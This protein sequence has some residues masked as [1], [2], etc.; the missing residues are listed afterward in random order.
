MG[1]VWC[2]RSLQSFTDPEYQDPVSGSD[3]FAVL[4]F[5][6][7]LLALALAL[8]MFAQL[9]GSRAV[10]RASL[11]SAAGAATAGV[12]NLLEDALQMGFAFWLFIIGTLLASLGLIVLGLVVA[13][14]CQGRRRL[15][16]AVPVLTLIG[17]MLFE[18]G[19]GVV[20]AAVWLA[21]AAIS[22]RSPAR[23][24]TARAA[25]TTP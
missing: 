7:A 20:I 4:S 10:F 17:F 18:S 12:A 9:V 19:G 11:V 2:V 3:W 16:A 5:S 14:A 13:I 6:A 23:L 15:F 22:L 24:T 1:V 8:P 21:V 25:T